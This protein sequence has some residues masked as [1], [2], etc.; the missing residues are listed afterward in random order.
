MQSPVKFFSG[1]DLSYEDVSIAILAYSAL[2]L[3][4]SL[5]YQA[6]WFLLVRCG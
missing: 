5:W 4:L 1:S 6:V 3:S 2:S